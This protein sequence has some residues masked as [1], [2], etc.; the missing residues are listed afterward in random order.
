MCKSFIENPKKDV[1]EIRGKFLDMNFQHYKNVIFLQEI[2]LKISSGF[3][4]TR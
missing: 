3:S 1:K 2:P 4:S